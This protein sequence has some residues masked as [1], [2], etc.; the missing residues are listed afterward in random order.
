MQN[1]V[2]RWTQDDLRATKMCSFRLSGYV[3]FRL[4]KISNSH[5]RDMTNMINHLINI[6]YDRIKKLQ[7]NR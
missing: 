2:E 3:R 4:R 5:G 7:E 6:E 1:E